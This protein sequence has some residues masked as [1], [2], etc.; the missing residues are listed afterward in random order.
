MTDAMPDEVRY[1]EEGVEHRA[2]VQ[3]FLAIPLR[4]RV[5]MILS[6]AVL[7]FKAGEVLDSKLALQTLAESA[8][9]R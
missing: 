4:R 5:Q 7:F 2:T 1:I 3:E 8:R 6:G 9:K